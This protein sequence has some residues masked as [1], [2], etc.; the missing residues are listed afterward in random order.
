MSFKNQNRDS[1]KDTSLHISGIDICPEKYIYYIPLFI[2]VLFGLSAYYVNVTP[3][4]IIFWIITSYSGLMFLVYAKNSIFSIKPEDELYQYIQNKKVIPITADYEIIEQKLNSESGERII[5]ADHIKRIYDVINL[6]SMKKG[7]LAPTLYIC[8]ESRINSMCF[9]H[10]GMK[11]IILSIPCLKLPY[12]ELYSLINFCLSLGI[13]NLSRKAFLSAKIYNAIIKPVIGI[14]SYIALFFKFP[15]FL[16]AH[17]ISRLIRSDV[18]EDFRVADLSVITDMENDDFLRLLTRADKNA[19]TFKNAPISLQALTVFQTEHL[20]FTPCSKNRV[21]ELLNVVEFN[22]SRPKITTKEKLTLEFYSKFSYEDGESLNS[23]IETR[24]QQIKNI[25][26]EIIEEDKPI[27][28]LHSIHEFRPEGIKHPDYGT[29]SNQSENTEEKIDTKD[30]E[31]TSTLNTLLTK[32]NKLE[33]GAIQNNSEILEKIS[34]ISDIYTVLDDNGENFF[35]RVY[36]SLPTGLAEE[37][38]KPQNIKSAANAIASIGS[39]NEDGAVFNFCKLKQIWLIPLITSFANSIKASSINEQNKIITILE[40]QGN[41]YNTSI[42]AIL[43]AL[44]KVLNISKNIKREDKDINKAVAIIL[45]WVIK[46]QS[47]SKEDSINICLSDHR[48]KSFMI[49]K[50]NLI[51]T[52]SV[53]DFADATTIV[54]SLDQTDRNRF[55]DIIE[56]IISGDGIITLNEVNIYHLLKLIFFC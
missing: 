48:L 17:I 11:I 43:Y 20:Q 3:L 55:L 42:Q 24:L 16:Y 15:F 7:W 29:P 52:I 5:T 44:I 4:S 36:R 56:N 54:H 37:I 34:K 40:K 50:E 33:L 10:N 26:K 22:N 45:N 46:Q 23:F 35:M 18:S 12:G 14:N 27:V 25:G 2:T 30:S 9:I 8:N 28:R 41:R 49:S 19:G 39:S 32:Q 21:S 6:I 31:K 1:L 51:S 13:S 38:G 47:S 53:S